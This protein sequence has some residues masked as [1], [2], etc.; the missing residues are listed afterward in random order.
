MDEFTVQEVAMLPGLIRRAMDCEVLRDFEV[1]ILA[2]A[3]QSWSPASGIFSHAWLN[4]DCVL[5]G[6]QSRAVREGN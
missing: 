2:R 4:P 6:C 3:A 1:M 5:N